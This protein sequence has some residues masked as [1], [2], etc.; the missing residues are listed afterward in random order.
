MNNT[1][2]ENPTAAA[3]VSTDWRKVGQS[4]AKVKSQKKIDKKDKKDKKE[5]KRDQ[6]SK[7]KAALEESIAIQ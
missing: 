1:K 7:H 4:F 3:K 6:K 2:Q 5:K